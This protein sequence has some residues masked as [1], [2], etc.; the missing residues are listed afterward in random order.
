MAAE[1]GLKVQCRLLDNEL[2][3]DPEEEDFKRSAENEVRLQ[4][5]DV[6]ISAQVRVDKD[7]EVL[8]VPAVT[9]AIESRRDFLGAPEPARREITISTLRLEEMRLSAQEVASLSILLC[10]MTALYAAEYDEA[11][12]FL[13][14]ASPRFEQADLFLGL[15]WLEKGNPQEAAE[16]LRRASVRRPSWWEALHFLRA[17]EYAL[18][19]TAEVEK[20]NRLMTELEPQDEAVRNF[21]ALFHLRRLALTL[22]HLQKVLET[23]EGDI[24]TAAAVDIASIDSTK[25]MI[26]ADAAYSASNYDDATRHAQNALK[27]DPGNG[28]AA[29]VFAKALNRLGEGER[30]IA[31]LNDYEQNLAANPESC[32]DLAMA[33]L[34]AGERKKGWEH[35]RRYL[36]NGSIA[37]ADRALFCQLLSVELPQLKS[38][39]AFLEASQRLRAR[40]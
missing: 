32:K 21:T 39:V 10:G 35:A 3:L 18:N 12:R 31:V 33:F 20:I 15:A 16:C 6:L 37:K 8:I 27:L 4:R 38:D 30:A 23:C 25:E 22:E 34:V 24:G 17:A 19:N 28:G 14:K 2:A 5:C 36:S 29:V 7:D 40:E 11:I 9:A 26:I 1:G 13:V